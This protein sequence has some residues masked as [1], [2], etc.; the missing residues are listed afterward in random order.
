M[1]IRRYLSSNEIK[2][3][4]IMFK[5]I[6]A[7]WNVWR[8]KDINSEP[9]DVKKRSKEEI[10]AHLALMQQQKDEATARKEPWVGM[11]TMDV[12]YNNLDK[13]AFELDWNDFYIARLIRAGYQGK[14]DADIIDQWFTTVCRNVVLETYE[15]E[16]ADPT[17]RPIDLGNGRREYK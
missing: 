4:D 9:V 16:I 13:G 14:S 1:G 12:D 10:N 8:N 11:L 2:G 15:Q 5:T 7:A 6:T 3:R 17:N